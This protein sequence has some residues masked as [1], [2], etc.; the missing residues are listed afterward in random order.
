MTWIFIEGWDEF[1]TFPERELRIY[2]WLLKEH[3]QGAGSLNEE[4][5]KKA[6]VIP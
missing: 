5:K 4:E 6:E 3:V 2:N 1:T